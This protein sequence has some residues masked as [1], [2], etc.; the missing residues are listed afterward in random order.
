V[1]SK[2]GGDAIKAVD[3]ESGEPRVEVVELLKVVAVVPVEV[4]NLVEC[5][6]RLWQRGDW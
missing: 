3:L 2:E 1:Q 6:C 5:I 4:E